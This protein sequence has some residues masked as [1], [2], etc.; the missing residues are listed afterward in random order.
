MRR[1]KISL[2]PFSEAAP[3]PF[4]S[5]E[6]AW[7]WFSQCQIAR[8]DGVRFTA[9]LGTFARPCDPDDIYRIVNTLYRRRV[10]G[11][12]HLTVLGRFG[13]RQVPPGPGS[14]DTP[15]ECT[16]WDEALDRLGTALRHK[17]I[18]S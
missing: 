9:G 13:L 10:L 17:G 3:V 8:L 14:G 15:G 18:V 16:L 11:A 4:D 5:A 6:D 2:R 7:L 12:G 1:G